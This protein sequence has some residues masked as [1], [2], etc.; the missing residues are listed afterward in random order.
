L[1]P[2]LDT[3]SAATCLLLHERFACQRLL[4]TVLP[5]SVCCRPFCLPASAADRFACEL[6]LQTIFEPASVCL[7]TRLT[8]L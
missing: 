3:I 8:E 5:A 1:A 7:Q 4:Q 2:F 6:L